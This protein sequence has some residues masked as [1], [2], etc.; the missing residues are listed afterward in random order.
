MSSDRDQNGPTQVHPAL[1]FNDLTSHIQLSGLNGLNGLN[2]MNGLNGIG[3]I[4][5]P[6][7]DRGEL[8]F[9]LNHRKFTFLNTQFQKR[10]FLRKIA[11]KKIFTMRCGHARIFFEFPYLVALE[12]SSNGS[13]F[14]VTRFTARKF[15]SRICLAIAEKI[16]PDRVNTPLY[17]IDILLIEF[18]NFPQLF[19]FLTSA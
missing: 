14:T 13:N 15:M 2:G 5:K 3:M 4:P 18:F 8:V 16:P 7:G 19:L 1:N 10:R 12:F 11:M 9:D 17:L 6:F